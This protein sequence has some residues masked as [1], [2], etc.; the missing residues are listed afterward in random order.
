MWKYD[1]KRSLITQTL[2]YTSEQ[3]ILREEI[4]SLKGVKDKL[5]GRIKELED[6]LKKTKDDLEKKS[7]Q[8]T[9][10]ENE[11]IVNGV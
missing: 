5:Q 4:L 6:D 11:V 10:G 1:K 7:Q 9:E 2:W 3:E 8:A